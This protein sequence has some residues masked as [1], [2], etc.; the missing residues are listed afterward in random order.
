[1][2]HYGSC[3]NLITPNEIV[4]LYN[5]DYLLNYPRLFLSGPCCSKVGERYPLYKSLSSGYITVCAIHL[6]E[7][8]PV[9][10][11]IHLLNN[12]GLVW[13]SLRSA[14]AFPVVASLRRERSDDRK[15]VCASQA[16][17]GRSRSYLKDCF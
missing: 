4:G 10:S 16:T 9:D 5:P 6:I 14:D 15:C 8:Y 1:M 17:F 3:Y 2:S 13:A 7:I 12:W 11:V